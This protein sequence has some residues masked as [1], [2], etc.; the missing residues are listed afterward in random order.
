MT[1]LGS[2]TAP[3]RPRNRRG[4]P[5]AASATAPDSKA[6]AGAR[7]VGLDILEGNP[8]AGKAYTGIALLNWNAPAKVKHVPPG[9]NVVVTMVRYGDHTLSDTWLLD[10]A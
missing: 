1:W 5:V 8:I 3:P 9:G 4:Q 2:W 7:S 10:F 6:A